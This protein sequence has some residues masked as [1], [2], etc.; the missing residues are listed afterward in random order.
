[1][2]KKQRRAR[3]KFTAEFKAEVVELVRGGGSIGEL[4]KELDLTETSVREWV[5]QAEVD[6]AAA[7]QGA[8]TSAER[9]EVA[10]LRRELKRV[11]MERDILKKAAVL[12]AKSGS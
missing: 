7:P 9:A 12:F 4:C 1:M 2:G 11:T 3:R 5:R 10:R 8:L 6:A